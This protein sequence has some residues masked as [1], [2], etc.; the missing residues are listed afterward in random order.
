MTT[1]HRSSSSR[2]LRGYGPLLGMLAALLVM[3]LLAPTVSPVE[4]VIRSTTNG[5]SDSADFESGE[6]GATGEQTTSGGVQ[7]TEGVSTCDGLQVTNDPYSPPCV[8]WNPKAN[9]GGATA[10]GVTGD[11]ITIALRDTGGPYDVGAVVSEL[12]GNNPGGQTTNR[13]DY[14]RTYQ[15]L[16]EYFNKRFQFYGRKL[17]LNFYD[18]QGSLVS[19]LLGG[20]QTEANADA[21]HVAQ[22]VKAFADVG[23]EAPVYAEALAKQKVISTNPVYPSRQWYEAQA[24]YAYG[25]FPDCSKVVDFI[26]EFA[27]KSLNGRKVVTGQFKGQARKYGLVYPNTPVYQQ[28]GDQARNELARVGYPVTDYKQYT[29]SLDAISQS[30]GPIASEFAN[31][32]IT[33]VLLV[34]DPLMPYFMTTNA[35][36]IGWFPEWINSGIAYM[37]AD[38]AGQ[39]MD[40]SQWPNSFGVSLTGPAEP[41]RA[42]YGYAAYQSIDPKT[43]PSPLVVAPIYYQL[44]LLSIGIQMAGPKLTPESFAAGMRSYKSPGSGALGTWALPKGDYSVSQDARVVWWDPKASSNFNGAAGAYRDNGQ[45]YRRGSL[46]TGDPQVA[47]P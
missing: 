9:N 46:P 29:L 44:Y 22:E 18:G 32:G 24:P 2:F 19:E 10:N 21:V 47:A 34:S 26:V 17:K 37:D 40:K 28:C 16:I 23:V 42:T 36:Q 30:A 8:V 15:T 12:T 41:A 3:S 4:R 39:L 5:G 25:R 45:R 27:E 7:L 35:T 14:L 13:D 11:T 1:T 33:T 31:R 20:G 38:W 43:S 6:P